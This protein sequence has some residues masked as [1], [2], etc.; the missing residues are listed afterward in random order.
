[1][2]FE[3]LNI[4]TPLINAIADLGL[5]ECTPIQAQAFPV[6]MSGKDVIGIAQTGTGKTF[7]FLLPL[8][9]MHVFNKTPNPRILILVPTRELVLQ[10]ADEAEKLSAYMNFTVGRAYGGTNIQTQK[11]EIF[12]GLD[13]LVAT[14]GRLLD[15]LLC[16]ALKA[17][18]I[19]KLVI[20]EV[21]E[22]FDLGFRPQLMKILELLPDKRQNI[23]FSASMTK[24]IESLIHNYFNFPQKIEIKVTGTPLENI[25]QY[26][27]Q[28]PNFLTKVN[29]LEI[30]LKENEAFTKV[31][32]F[33]ASKKKADRLFVEI[34]EKFPEIVGV[35][36]SNKSQNFRMQTVK[37]F[38]RGT[39]RVL[40]ATDIISRGLD[41][42]DISH[43][44]NYEIPEEP[45]NYMHRIGRTGRAKNDGIAINFVTPVEEEN[46]KAIEELMQTEIPE[47]ELPENLIVEEELLEEEKEE[48]LIFKKYTRSKKDAPIVDK[49]PEKLARNVKRNH[50]NQFTRYPKKG[51]PY[52]IKENQKKR[53]KGSE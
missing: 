22:M 19:N 51:V 29:L 11:N 34:E 7:A 20:D 50:G 9:R 53:N 18:Y 21:D 26:V 15:L 42:E 5:Y 13:L 17:K 37:R 40:I 43:V 52:Y 23:M 49:N 24:Q 36:H 46:R 10:V 28:V 38:Q 41:L 12:Q 14:P 30:L 2:N 6:I 45:I 39:Y 44:I 25:E 27:F 33:V 32:V 35:I 4:N 3:Q 48:K 47:L 1:M 16:G 31:L 8:L